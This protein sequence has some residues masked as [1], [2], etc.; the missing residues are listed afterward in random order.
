MKF[1]DLFQNSTNRFKTIHKKLL[2]K[3][4]TKN[5]YQWSFSK[6]NADAIEFLIDH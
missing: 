4:K 6:K 5:L 2:F 1:A 3:I